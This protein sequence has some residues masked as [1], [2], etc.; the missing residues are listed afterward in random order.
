MSLELW[1]GT[2]SW[3]ALNATLQCRLLLLGTKESHY[4]FFR[5]VDV[6]QPV[7]CT[8]SSEGVKTSWMAVAVVQ[9]ERAR[10][11]LG[12]RRCWR[13]SFRGRTHRTG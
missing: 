13:R 12:Y 9:G 7:F 11:K 1:D 6:T 5:R 8:H 10:S 3:R 4:I 2:V